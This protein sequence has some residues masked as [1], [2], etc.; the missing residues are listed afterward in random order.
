MS[1]RGRRGRSGRYGALVSRAIL[2][3][4]VLALALAGCTAGGAPSPAPTVTVT[5]TATPDA[6]P[7]PTAGDC[8]SIDGDGPHIPVVYTVYTG[9]DATA[10]TISYTG[11]DPDGTVRE[12]TEEVTGPVATRVGYPC[13]PEASGG[14]WTPT[15]T[16]ST[17][18]SIA[19]VLA[20]GGKLVAT[21]SALAEGAAS[22]SVDCSG[23]PGR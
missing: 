13:S 22:I 23:N 15:A 19:C 18:D 8:S 1:I 12:I 4:P 9:D 2:A 14:I 10:T 17:P 6:P 16:S 21:D 5:A 11:F 3:L 20:Y 7:A